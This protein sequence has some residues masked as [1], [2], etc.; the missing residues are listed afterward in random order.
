MK[1]IT[2]AGPPS[3]GKTSIAIRT[4]Q[5]LR[6]EGLRAGVVKFDC[7]TGRDGERYRAAGLPVLSGISGNACPDHFFVSNIVDC[8]AWGHE[9]GLD[10]LL[11]ES[12]GLCNRCAPH[13]RGL[14]AVC[15]LDNLAGVDTPFKIGPMLKTADLVVITKAD[16]V[17]QAEREVF[18]HRVRQVNR[19]ARILF[20]NGITGQGAWEIGQLWR[21]AAEDDELTG[22]RLRFSLPS[23]VCSYCF[24][25]TKIGHEFQRG[26]VRRIEIPGL[27]TGGEQEQAQ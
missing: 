8:A 19:K 21:D 13:I 6:E 5:L 17:S 18:A 16:I 4:L 10:L 12:A 3:S 7:L 14:Y 2:L 26:V 22:G 27:E 20:A 11:S 23:A 9:Q 15:V 24:G 1:L 25:Q